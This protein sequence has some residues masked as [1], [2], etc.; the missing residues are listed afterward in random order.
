MNA[1]LYVYCG[2]C[3]WMCRAGLCVY[4]W[5]VCVCVWLCRAGLCMYVCGGMCVDVW[6]WVY[7]CM[8]VGVCEDGCV[9]VGL[10]GGMCV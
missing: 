5:G 3:L 6:V 2:M 1:R 9:G 7:V 4:V 8:C 10:C